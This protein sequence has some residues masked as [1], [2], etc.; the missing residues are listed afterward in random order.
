MPAG[1]QRCVQLVKYR[2]CN[3]LIEVIEEEGRK[4]HIIAICQ[5]HLLYIS[6]NK[7]H[8]IATCIAPAGKGYHFFR[9]IYVGDVQA[10]RVV[11][12]YCLQYPAGAAACNKHPRAGGYGFHKVLLRMDKRMPKHQP[13][14]PVVDKRN[15]IVVVP[16]LI[17]KITKAPLTAGPLYITSYFTNYLL[18]IAQRTWNCR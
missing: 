9:R 2:I 6:G 1:S 12:C 17:A 16:H 10:C 15:S 3:L 14:H 4:Y 11:R 7:N 8:F 18:K 13:G 5:R